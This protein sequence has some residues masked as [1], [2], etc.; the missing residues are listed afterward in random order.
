[1]ARQIGGALTFDPAEICLP[2]VSM[3]P[4]REPVLVSGITFSD[5]HE[6]P[7]EKETT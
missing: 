1:L 2:Q 3:R 5:G 6:V 7:S 4:L